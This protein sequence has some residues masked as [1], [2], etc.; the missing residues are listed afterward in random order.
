MGVSVVKVVG[1]VCL[2]LQTLILPLPT[3]G[4]PLWRTKATQNV[5]LASRLPQPEPKR[6]DLPGISQD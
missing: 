6:S 2:S 4:D 5:S 1:V 3:A